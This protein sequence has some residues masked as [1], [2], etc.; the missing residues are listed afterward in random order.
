MTRNS[1]YA[2]EIAVKNFLF[3]REALNVI[4][5]ELE[6]LAPLIGVQRPIIDPSYTA[7]SMVE[8]LLD[9]VGGGG[10]AKLTPSKAWF[11]AVVENGLARLLLLE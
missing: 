11:K 10:I 2:T 4:S 3:R 5:Q 6:H 9:H 8:G 7:D 1:R